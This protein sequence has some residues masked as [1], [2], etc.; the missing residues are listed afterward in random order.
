[1]FRHLSFLMAYMKNVKSKTKL[2]LR[3]AN[4]HVK[5]SAVILRYK[6]NYN[7]ARYIP[8]LIK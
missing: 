4:D 5:R 2:P 8:Q 1:M 6:K 3:H 7:I